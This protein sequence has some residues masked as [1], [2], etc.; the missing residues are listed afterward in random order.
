MQK[1]PFKKTFVDHRVQNVPVASSK[2]SLP[3]LKAKRSAV[4]KTRLNSSKDNFTTRKLLF[5]HK[6]ETEHS[7]ELSSFHVCLLLAYFQS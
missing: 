1:I 4:K 5:V 2:T 7:F 3:W 6:K